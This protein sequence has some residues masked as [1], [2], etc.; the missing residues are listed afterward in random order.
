MSESP[1]VAPAAGQQAA[2]NANPNVD[3][4]EVAAGQETPNE[5]S[6]ETAA[7]ARE[8]RRLVLQEYADDDEIVMVVDGKEKVVPMKEWRRNTQRTVSADQRYREA[9]ERAR[10]AE[11]KERRAFEQAAALRKDLTDPYRFRAAASQLGLNPRQLAEQ[12]IQIEHEEAQL[13]PE[14]RKLR[15]YEQF[16]AQQQEIER[17]RQEAA[18]EEETNRKALDLQHRF[19]RVMDMAGVPTDDEDVRD[20]VLERMT[21]FADRIRRTEGRSPSIREAIDDIHQTMDKIHRAAWNR[22]P[23]AERVKQITPEEWAEYQRIQAAAKPNTIAEAPRTD[24]Q[25]QTANQPRN[26]QGQFVERR[27]TTN[28]IFSLYEQ[29]RR[30]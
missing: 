12:L 2:P 15:E 20:L 28:D 16:F 30:T 3:P 8:R 1:N 22:Q 25:T 29:S 14:Q 18:R 21:T 4:N 17:Q 24:R 5:A 26:Q 27:M 6:K 9:T 11:E 23:A 10:A 7:E 13:T 19:E